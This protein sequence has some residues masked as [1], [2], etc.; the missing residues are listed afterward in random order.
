M[1][2]RRGGKAFRGPH[3]RWPRRPRPC[4]P[5]STPKI[6]RPPRWKGVAARLLGE[7]MG[8]DNA[9]SMAAGVESDGGAQL[10]EFCFRESAMILASASVV[11]APKAL[12]IFV[13]SASHK[14][15]LGKG[16]FMTM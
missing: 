4:N 12:I 8:A 15:A 2:A 9:D 1:I 7:N 3:C 14:A 6:R 16:E 5:L 11:G 13:T 10:P